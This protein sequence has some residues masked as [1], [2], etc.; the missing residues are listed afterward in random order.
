MNK[1]L[2]CIHIEIAQLVGGVVMSDLCADE[3]SSMSQK[4]VSFDSGIIVII[5][6]IVL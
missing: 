5:V 3:G 2:I 4:S 1:L 6:I